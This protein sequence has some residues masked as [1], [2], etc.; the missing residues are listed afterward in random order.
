MKK[1]FIATLVSLTALSSLNAVAHTPSYKEKDL[2]G[3]WQCESL[4]EDISM[5]FISEYMSN[6]TGIDI[7]KVNMILEDET[8]LSYD[9]EASYRYH[10][11]GNQLF[12]SGQLDKFE[13]KHTPETLAKADAEILEFMDTFLKEGFAEQMA[14][15]QSITIT[16]LS[17]DTLTLTDEEEDFT[18]SCK[19]IKTK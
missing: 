17:K 4:N 12:S 1:L 10:I 7:S 11:K 16:A 3:T 18:I 8:V 15:E 5:S 19:R 2:I 6:N 14:E 13:A 9:I